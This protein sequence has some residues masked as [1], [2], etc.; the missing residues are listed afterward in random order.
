[1]PNII[2]KNIKILEIRCTI[3]IVF[4]LTA[5]GP[6][7]GAGANFGTVLFRAQVKQ[8]FEKLSTD[9]KEFLLNDLG[10]I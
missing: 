5:N 8:K 10:V 3:V 2:I 1:M 6:A 4:R 7:V 9:K